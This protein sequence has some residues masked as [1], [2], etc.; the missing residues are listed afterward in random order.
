MA[1]TAALTANERRLRRWLVAVAVVAGLLAIAIGTILVILVRYVLPTTPDPF[2]RGPYVVAVGTTTATLRWQVDGDRQVRI[3]ATTADGRTVVG[4]DGRLTGLS[5]G[6]RQGWVAEVDGQARA[7]G[8]VTTAPSDPTAPVRFVAFGDYGTGGDAEHAVGRVGAA[9]APAFSLIPGDNVYIAAHPALFDRNVFRPM[10]ALLAQGPFYST[11]GDHDI[12]Y[13][14][15]RDIA[16]A[17]GLPNGG[18][19]YV[20]DHGPIRIVVLGLAGDAED[21]PVLR[22]ALARPGPRSVYVVV[23]RPPGADNPILPIARGRVTAIVAGH[24]HRYERRRVGGVPV[25][26]IG[27]GGAPRS[28][29]PSFTPRSADAAASI[30]EY[31]LVR[32]DDAASGV[33][34]A[35][36]DAA[37]RVRDRA[38]LR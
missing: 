23:H 16:E 32:V 1:G 38:R 2:T 35:F 28:A 29:N 9:Q 20:V 24:N 7:W 34:I 13:N 12:V 8:A 31:G 11:I 5:P 17:L 14:N 30:A 6:A 36:I 10:R 27:T 25:L 19:R 4:A 21:L 18:H 3:V 37:G 15:G 33:E 26:T 22:E